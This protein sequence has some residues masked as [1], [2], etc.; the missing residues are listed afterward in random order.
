M[1]IMAYLWMFFI[2]HP[3]HTA[4][5]LKRRVNNI[6]K[7]ITCRNIQVGGHSWGLFCM[8]VQGEL[9]DHIPLILLLEIHGVGRIFYS[10]M[11]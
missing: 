7:P 11:M 6:Q 9:L 1:H 2:L 3:T 5:T 4:Y 8:I 10:A